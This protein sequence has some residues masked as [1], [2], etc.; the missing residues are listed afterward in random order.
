MNIDIQEYDRAYHI[1]TTVRNV[2]RAIQQFQRQYSNSN[3]RARET[4]GAIIVILTTSDYVISLTNHSK[5]HCGM[6][7]RLGWAI[8]YNSVTFIYLIIFFVLTF[9]NTRTKTYHV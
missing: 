7:R 2:V 3:P 5:F 4:L 1:N 9:S 6:L 8:F